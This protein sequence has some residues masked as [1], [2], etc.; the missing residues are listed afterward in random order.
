[1]R[2]TAKIEGMTFDLASNAFTPILYRQLFKRDFLRELQSYRKL[3]GKKPSEFTEEDEKIYEEHS[4]SFSRIA[5]VM[6]K[7]AEIETADKLVQLSINDYYE[8]LMQFDS[9]M[10]FSEA[11]A[12]SAI[13]RAWTGNAED[14]SVEAK[15][16]ES[17]E[18]EK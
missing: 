7:Q 5:F 8:W 1:M 11:D 6:A 17:R 18:T 4:D 3:R 10:A 12:L 9:P 13:L 15:N 16:A 14:M 2:T